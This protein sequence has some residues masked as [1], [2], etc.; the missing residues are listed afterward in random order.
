MSEREFSGGDAFAPT[1]MEYRVCRIMMKSELRG[2]L[3]AYEMGNAGAAQS[4]PSFGPFQY[5]IGAN[6]D[7]RLFSNPSLKAPRTKRGCE[8]SASRIYSSSKT[9][10]TS[11][12][13]N[14][15]APTTRSTNK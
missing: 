5:D 4:G 2:G 8:S 3:G 1:S 9:T 6:Q 13:T 10:S 15:R 11:L 14:L 12:S 7:G